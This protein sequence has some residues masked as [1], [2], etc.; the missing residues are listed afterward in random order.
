MIIISTMKFFI[1]INILCFGKLMTN[2]LC[3]WNEKSTV[4]FFPDTEQLIDNTI[5]I[6]TKSSVSVSTGFTICLRIKL[7]TQNEIKVFSSSQNGLLFM[8]LILKDFREGT[9]VFMFDSLSVLFDLKNI[10]NFYL[11]WNSACFVNSRQNFRIAING[12]EILNQNV[13]KIPYIEKLSNSEITLGSEKF[14][15]QVKDFNIWNRSL[16]LHEI[17]GVHKSCN[18]SFVPNTKPELLFWLEANITFFGNSTQKISEDP[19]KICK[20]NIVS[21]QD[22]FILQPYYGN[23]EFSEQYCTSLNGKLL[24]PNEEKEL[25]NLKSKIEANK[26]RCNYDFWTP[27]TSYNITT[28]VYETKMGMLETIESLE[29]EN[30][31]HC[32]YYSFQTGKY[33]PTNCD[34]KICSIYEIEK[35]RLIYNIS[36]TTAC[37][38]LPVQI[39]IINSHHLSLNFQMKVFHYFI[40]FCN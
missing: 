19:L 12:F 11:N 24:L 2:V 4:S 6:Q 21:T 15:G 26:N 9:G 10:S 33:Y 13:K 39:E 34:K 37:K 36:G 23:F 20:E 17:Q 16:N 28:W 35:K 29:V 5:K 7:H 22:T 40:I 18:S 27:A 32:V 31:I 14:S 3:I 25:E 8:S 38:P 1:L 30:S